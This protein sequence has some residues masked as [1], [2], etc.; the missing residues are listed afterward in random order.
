[1]A[2]QRLRLAL[3]G[4]TVQ[5]NAK[6]GHCPICGA[7]FFRIT[8]AGI[9]CPLCLAAGTLENGVP[10]FAPAPDNRWQPDA[11][12]RHFTEW[13]Q[14]TGETFLEKRPTIRPLLR[15]YRQ[16]PFPFV[17]PRDVASANTK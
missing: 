9:E 15:P 3:S 4:Q 16:R 8:D 10:T 2:G 6:P 5:M 17:S 13:I 14:N 12:K 11:L 1:M 7:D